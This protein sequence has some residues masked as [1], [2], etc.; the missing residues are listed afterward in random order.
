MAEARRRL[1]VPLLLLGLAAAVCLLAWA[2]S[3]SVR[4]SGGWY[5]PIERAIVTGLVV[6]AGVASFAVL[7]GHVGLRVCLAA[8]MAL[9]PV[10][11]FFAEASGHGLS[12]SVW[13][14]QRIGLL[15]AIACT[16]GAVGLVLRKAWARWMALAAAIGGVG[17]SGLNIVNTIG[18][19]HEMTWIHAVAISFSAIVG[20][21]LLGPSVRAQFEREGEQSVWSSQD[22]SVRGIRATVLSQLVAIPMLLVYAWLQPIVPQT[23]TMALVLAAVLG[24]GALLTMGRKLLGA[25]CLVLAGPALLA[26]TAATAWLAHASGD[27]VNTSIAG[28]YACFWAPAGL[29]STLTGLSL[30]KPVWRLWSQLD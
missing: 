15:C 12:Y 28:Y 7:R 22:W 29:I 21:A 11:H 23:R 5:G 6:S 18:V 24:L 17:T 26:L 25:L 10:I 8:V 9:G 27:P 13:D 1:E 16:G 3:W 14:S 30:I 19:Q 4:V 2:A 20:L